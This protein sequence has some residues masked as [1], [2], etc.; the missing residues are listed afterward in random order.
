MTNFAGTARDLSL[1]SELG[2]TRA[3]RG[4]GAVVF[5]A[6]SA[7]LLLGCGSSDDAA[8]ARAVDCTKG[9]WT[10]T[11]ADES[12]MT[13]M[14]TL[15]EACCVANAYRDA[16][17][18]DVEGCKN[19]FRSAGVSHDATVRT[20]C[21][22]ELESLSSAGKDCLP[23]AWNLEDPCLRLVYEPSGPQEPG[24]PCVNRADCKG[25]PG[26]IAFCSHVSSEFSPTHAVCLRL[27]RGS[28]DSKEPC[29][30]TMTPD[31]VI[32][33]A[34]A[35]VAG[36]NQPLTTGSVCEERSGLQCGPG[37]N[38]A[39]WTCQR[40]GAAGAACEYS[41]TCASRQCLTSDG[42]DVDL[43]SDPGTCTKQVPAGQSCDEESSPAVCDASSFCHYPDGALLP[44]GTCETKHPAGTTCLNDQECVSGACDSDASTCSTRTPS[45]QL[46]MF[47]YCAR[48]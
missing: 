5:F 3:M 33:A 36:M 45:E 44:G 1:R 25:A 42:S 28:A 24:E 7:A 4:L 39:S 21:L 40:L 47:A 38:P 29:L 2:D 30:G 17:A 35:T 34:A 16:G 10:P 32:T 26:S 13:D 14:C 6:M 12:L 22:A 9:C 23:E 27:H 46:S 31:G 41:S 48:L 11:A 20:A 8:P 37:N 18:T 19:I 15:T 43:S